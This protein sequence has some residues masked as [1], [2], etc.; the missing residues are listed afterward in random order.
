[1]YDYLSI[2]IVK[3][4]KNSVIKY[5][6]DG[7]MPGFPII[8]IFY[9]YSQC[10]QK[11]KLTFIRYPVIYLPLANSVVNTLWNHIDYIIVILYFE[12][13]FHCTN[14][15]HCNGHGMCN[16]FDGKCKCDPDWNLELDCSSKYIYLEELIKWKYWMC[17]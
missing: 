8:A 4:Q 7:L 12:L 6:W 1:M 16:L 2:W 17:F 11:F 14:D 5:V 13:D 15:S 10:L 3:F 9:S